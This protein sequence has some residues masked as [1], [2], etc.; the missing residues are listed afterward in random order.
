MATFIK[1]NISLALTYSFR[2][3]VHCHHGGKHGSMQVDMVLELRILH[4]G[5]KAAK[6]TVNQLGISWTYETLKLTPTVTHLLQQGDSY[7]N[8]AIP[9]MATSY[10]P[11]IQIYGS[12]GW[13]LPIKTITEPKV[14]GLL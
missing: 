5:P 8:K 14:G 10:G 13:G 1:E 3:L 6:A 4:L 9:P 11:I 12:M 7:S 2:G